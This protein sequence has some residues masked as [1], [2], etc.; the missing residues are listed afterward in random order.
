MLSSGLMTTLKSLLFAVSRRPS[1]V[2]MVT[3]S[4]LQILVLSEASGLKSISIFLI[5]V[6]SF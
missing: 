5:R 6:S 1:I 4:I 3:S 2:S